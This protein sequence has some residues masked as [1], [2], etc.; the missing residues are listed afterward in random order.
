MFVL[1]LILFGGFIVSAIVYN[2]VLATLGKVKR[3]VTHTLDDWS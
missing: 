2:G 1:L 3:G